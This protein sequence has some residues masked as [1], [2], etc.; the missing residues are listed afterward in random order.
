MA[1]ESFSHLPKQQMEQEIKSFRARFNWMTNLIGIGIQL[2]LTR[3]VLQRVGT[4]AAVLFLPSGLGIAALGILFAPSLWSV[5]VALGCDSVFRYSIHRAGLELLILPL[6]PVTRK[7]IKL[8]IDVFI[9]RFGRAA[10]A[11]II[12]AL[13]T[14]YLPIGLTGTAA[15]MAGLTA[16]GLVVGMKLRSCYVDAFRQQ[17]ARREVDLSEVNRF[18]TDPASLRLLVS[19]LQSPHERQILY[20]LGL[21]QSARGFDFSS[22]LLPLL[23]HRSPFVREEAAR[24]LHALPGDRQADAREL[25][26]DESEEV[27]GAAVEYL[28]TLEPAETGERLRQLLDD[29]NP[30]IRLAA[31]RCAAD[32]PDSVYRPSM[33]L[34]HDLLSIDGT[35]AIQAHAVAALL[36]ARLPH[37]ESV[38][39]LHTLLQDP[40]PQVAADAIM[41]AGKA[42]RQELVLEIVPLLSNRNL[43]GASRQALASMGAGITADLAAVLADEAQDTTVRMEVSWIL[44]RIQDAK[45]VKILVEN[46]NSRDF[47]VKY[48][49]VKA[50]SRV[51]ARNPDLPGDKWV[52]EVHL[53]AQT[54][55]YYE[56]LALFCAMKPKKNGDSRLV[57]RALQEH[58]D[59]QMEIVFRLLGLSY[60]QR[61]IY[62]AYVALKGLHREKRVAAIEFLDN[63]LKR[64][65]K[66]LILPLLEEEVPEHLVTRIAPVFN[67][68]VPG[69]DDAMQTLLQQPNPW[70]KACT[71]HAV[72][73]ELNTDLAPFCRE[74][75]KD[76]DPL[77]RETAGWALQQLSAQQESQHVDKS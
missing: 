24:T 28:C 58:L 10:A 12:L 70:L 8:F 30:D 40:R 69:R 25:L 41:A 71:L 64:E 76:G 33:S 55:A 46:L 20:A 52:L 63:I 32:L 61:D 26:G 56:G 75:L 50:L 65:V 37:S 42:E 17:L 77:V 68:H 72:G 49:I 19:T 54:M 66:S 51:H 13:T 3:F 23:Q 15:V 53:I 45:A 44:G 6:S 29:P 9:D 59:R 18:V 34:V 47:R 11:F 48:Q 4:W 31:A 39:F 62:S 38:P 21:L 14:R 5:A 43:R 1:Q 2:T 60:P 57:S 36:A 16:A 7:K 67:L 73:S 27:R 22:Q 35:R 74:L